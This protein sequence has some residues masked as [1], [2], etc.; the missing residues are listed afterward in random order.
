MIGAALLNDHATTHQAKERN[1]PIVVP[2]GGALIQ[3]IKVPHGGNF[4]LAYSTIMNYMSYE[5]SQ[6]GQR[7][8]QAARVEKVKRP[9]ISSAGTTEYFQSR[10]GDYV[11]ATKLIAGA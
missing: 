2:R 10:W 5:T 8:I 3:I 11:R 6:G 7:P 9:D 4:L 1:I